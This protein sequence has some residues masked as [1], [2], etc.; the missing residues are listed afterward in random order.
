[1]LKKFAIAAC[2]VAGIVTSSWAA[3]V[4]ALTFTG[5]PSLSGTAFYSARGYEFSVSM[6]GLKATHLGIFDAAADGL[7]DSHLVGLWKSDG[8]LITSATVPSG[9]SGLLQDSMRYVDIPDIVLGIGSYVVGAVY[10][11]DSA[12][13]QANVPAAN[14]S[15]APGITYIE[16]RYGSCCFPVVLP[17]PDATLPGVGGLLGGTLMID[18]GDNVVPEPASFVLALSA[19]A[20]LAVNRR[21]SVQ[22]QKGP[23]REPDRRVGGVLAAVVAR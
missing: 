8:T 18:A 22:L 21:R 12:D 9:T 6:S 14:L 11:E 13:L 16:M 19:L 7:A 23:D 15:T 20:A 4:S 2:A 17:F 1:M 3:P 10:A 5:N